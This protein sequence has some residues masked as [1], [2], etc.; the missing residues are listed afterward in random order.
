MKNLSTLITLLLLIQGCSNPENQTE[1]YK[2][3]LTDTINHTDTYFGKV[4][5]DPYQWL[6]TILLPKQKNG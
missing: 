4:I 1:M 6:E 5:Q 2:F 3:P